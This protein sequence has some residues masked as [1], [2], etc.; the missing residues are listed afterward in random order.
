MTTPANPT[1]GALDVEWLPVDDLIPNARNAKKHPPEQVAQIAGS[2]RAFGFNAPILL[3]AQG[4]VLAG[5]GRLMAARQ[6]GLATVPC[7]RLRHLTPN[8]ARAYLIA[9]NR[10]GETGGTGWDWELLRAELADLQAVAEV[11]LELLGF[12]PGDLDPARNVDRAAEAASLASRFMGVPFSV[13]NAREGWWKERRRS[14]LALGIQSELGRAGEGGAGSKGLLFATSSQPPEVYDQKNAL[15]AQLG[16][17]LTWAEFFERQPEKK[18]MGSTSIFD[19]VLCELAY[20]WFSP[21]GGLVLDPFAGGSVRGV[22]AGWLGRRYV[23]IDI[24]AE[25]VEAN[26]AQAESIFAPGTTTTESVPVFEPDALTPVERRGGVWFKRDDLFWFKGDPRANGGKVRAVLRLAKRAQ[27][28]VAC[29]DRVSTQI[30][31]VGVLASLLGLSARIHTATGETTEGM[32]EAEAAGAVLVR[33]EAGYLSVLKA[34]AREDAAARG[35]C[36]IPWACECP[37]AIAA[38]RPQAA[39][40]PREM[41]RL[42]VCVGSGTSL[43][44]ILH[45][46]A[47]AGIQ[48]P[49]LG[50]MVGGPPQERL[51]RL[52]PPGWAAQVELV[53]AQEEEFR[54]PAVRT[55]FEGVALDPYY[56]AKAIPF[57]REGDCLWVVG[58]RPVEAAPIRIE[59]DWIV[60][61]ARDADTLVEADADFV[62]SCP[63]Y[64]DLEVYSEA[65]N[66]LS[67]VAREQGYEAFLETYR[68]AIA[69]ACSRLK[70]DRFAAFVV[71]DMRDKSGVFRGFVGDTV[72]AF[73]AAGLGLYNEAILV[74][75]AGSLAMRTGAQFAATR[76]LGRTHQ[77]LLVFVKGNAKRATQACG[78]VEVEEAAL[79]AAASD[80]VG[81]RPQPQPQ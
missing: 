50:V 32:A 46:L 28:L 69:A 12:T 80:S 57:L 58:S 64:A 43:S 73:R 42:V 9:D 40:L 41:K 5:H 47:D 78:P 18:G 66:D 59:P 14:W 60:G 75:A 4:G 17:P 76:K 30:P 38:V 24:R 33:H 51:A 16:R 77:Q 21:P 11:P 65:A 7:V 67:H 26:R 35:W 22:V 44:G 53:P 1:P 70:P 2:I 6:L 52:A 62:F 54:R 31:R 39:N 19:P 29:G 37:E 8:E 61:D 25:Q 79:T 71:G 45:G 49:V 72:E 68:A 27:G 13:L 63:P 81:A 15:E 36:E 34:R 10:L 48:V 74:T 20:R 55:E 3:D 23:G 56:E